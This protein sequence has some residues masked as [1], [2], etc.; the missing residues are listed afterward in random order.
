MLK[1]K[2]STVEPH[3]EKVVVNMVLLMITQSKAITQEYLKEK[4]P[5]MDWTEKKMLQQSFETT[6]QE[7]Q[8]T[9]PLLPLQEVLNPSPNSIKTERIDFEIIKNILVPPKPILLKRML[10]KTPINVLPKIGQ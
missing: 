10:P 3:K 6:I 5:Q 4:E 2:A 1:G 7:L 8:E 9:D